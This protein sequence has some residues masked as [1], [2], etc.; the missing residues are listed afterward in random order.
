MN[1]I[2][3]RGYWQSDVEKNTEIA[4]ERSFRLGFGT[5]TDV[6]DCQGKLVISHDIPTGNEILMSRFL[7][8]YKASG[9]GKTL[10]LN[11]KSDGLQY[12]L[13][14]LLEDYEVLN[15][16]IF[17][18][19]VPDALSSIKSGLT[20]YTRQSEYEKECSFYELSN[21]VWMD[22]FSTDWIDLQSIKIHLK[23]NK[24]VCIVSPELH[25][26]EYLS[27]WKKYKEITKVLDSKNITLCTDLPELAEELIN[28]KN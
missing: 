23:N 6:R 2:S 8:I 11:I 26:R 18:M 9:C 10:A 13:M 16:F 15:Y 21:G 17:D 1:I 3:H 24:K 20:A 22:E 27:K 28:G 5:E 12:P 14:K 19:S 25:G 4:F 7:E